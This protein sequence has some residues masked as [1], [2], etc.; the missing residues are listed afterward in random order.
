MRIFYLMNPTIRTNPIHLSLTDNDIWY[1]SKTFLYDREDVLR[2]FRKQENEDN[3]FWWVTVAHG[4]QEVLESWWGYNNTDW[5]GKHFFAHH[6]G[7]K[8]L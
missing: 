3:L 1:G 6:D 4:R 5:N 8:F 7:F 2:F